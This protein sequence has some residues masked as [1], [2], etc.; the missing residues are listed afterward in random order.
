[1]ADE[2]P[3]GAVPPHQPQQHHQ[4]QPDPQFLSLSRQVSDLLS[5]LRLLEERYANLRREH[6]TTSQNMIENHQNLSKQL[7][8]LNDTVVELKRGLHDVKEQ[9][10]T[11]SGELAD[12][13]TSHD[14]KALERYLDLWQ[15]LSFLTRKQAQKL[16][17]E[18]V[19]NPRKFYKEEEGGGA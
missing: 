7:R 1:M 2:Q 10:G 4:K 16:I 19:G 11:M 17:Q 14:L 8:K 13:A 6:Q 18:A 9:V 12:A 3:Q 5:R 15:P